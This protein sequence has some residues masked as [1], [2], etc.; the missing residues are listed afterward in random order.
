[1]IISTGVISVAVFILLCIAGIAIRIY[2]QKYTY[3]KN[4]AKESEHEDNV[5]A[6]AALKAEISMQNTINESQKEYFF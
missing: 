3:K 5:E 1:M 6:A 2:L 4:E